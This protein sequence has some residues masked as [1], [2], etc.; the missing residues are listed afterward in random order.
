MKKSLLLLMILLPLALFASS[1][2]ESTTIKI[3]ISKIVAHP[4]LDAI[5]Q[6]IMDTVK[7]VLPGCCF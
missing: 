4:A 7:E 3:G 1:N 5:E 6:G 2:E